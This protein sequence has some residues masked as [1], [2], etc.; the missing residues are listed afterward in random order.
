MK[1]LVAEDSRTLAEELRLTLESVGHE[2]TIAANGKDAL[3]AL[4]SGFVPDLLLADL[5]MPEMGGAELLAQVRKK[6]PNLRLVAMT[7][8]DGDS[9]ASVA[10]VRAMDIPLLRKPFGFEDLDKEI[11]AVSVTFPDVKPV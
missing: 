9:D 1:I 4:E 10:A 3:V 5:T 6:W 2:P 7:A 11:A 8:L